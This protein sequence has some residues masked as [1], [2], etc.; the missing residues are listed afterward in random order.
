MTRTASRSRNGHPRPLSQLWDVQPFL[1]HH[2]R[3]QIRCGI[4]VVDVVRNANEVLR[5]GQRV[6]PKA[7]FYGFP[8]DL[9]VWTEA[10]VSNWA[11]VTLEADFV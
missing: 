3:A 2:L 7:P 8:A 10:L 4:G 1:D 9:A 5:I 6:L 11:Q